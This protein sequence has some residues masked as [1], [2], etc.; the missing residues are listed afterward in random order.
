MATTKAKHGRAYL[1]TSRALGVQE[2]SGLAPVGDGSFLVVD[3]EHGIFRC[4]PDGASVQLDAGKGLADLEGIVV[5]P[6]GRHA[7]VVSERDGSIWRFVVEGDGLGAG[8]RLGQLPQLSKKRNQGWEGVAFA[9]AGTLSEQM[10]LVAAH[11]VKPRRIGL[12]DPETLELHMLLK[13]PK[14]ARKTIGELNDIAIDADGRILLL[15]GKSGYIAEM[16]L[17]GESLS[18]ARVYSIK[19]DSDDVPE[20]I[21]IDAAGRVWICT[22]GKGMLRELKLEP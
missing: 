11:Q 13:L 9:P 12:F 6:D 22:D 15:S 14:A 17:G 3:D 16:Y 2:A 4:S 8:E 10:T 19:T 18:L 21:S 1:M 5:T 20:G 7:Y